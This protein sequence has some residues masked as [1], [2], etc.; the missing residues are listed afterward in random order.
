MAYSF[1]CSTT[2]FQEELIRGT[3]E[4]DAHF[5]LVKRLLFDTEIDFVRK[6]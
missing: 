2:F 5:L 1:S 3:I 4:L 6:G